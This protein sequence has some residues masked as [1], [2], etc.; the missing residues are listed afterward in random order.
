MGSRA[1]KGSE[2]D[3]FEQVIEFGNAVMLQHADGRNIQ[4]ARNR[5]RCRNGTFELLAEFC[6]AKPLNIYRN[7]R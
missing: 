6:G 7:I 4:R 3:L 1:G 5:F 2:T